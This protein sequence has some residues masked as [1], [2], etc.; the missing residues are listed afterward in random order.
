MT[1][2]KSY[3]SHVV[4]QCFDFRRM[5]DF[6]TGP[7]GFHLSDIGVARGHEMAF[8]TLDP[9]AEHHQLALASGRKGEGG[10][11][12]HLAFGV[13]SLKDLNERLQHLR[14]NNVDGIE[15]WTHASMLSV[16][17]RDPENNR[18]EFFMETPYYVQQ[19]V[20]EALD[21]D[22]GAD[23]SV[24]WEAI[25]DKFRGNPGFQPMVQWKR[26]TALARDATVA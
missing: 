8:L 4:L 18:L 19:P 5:V 1:A 10:A 23:E 12:H 9:A 11:L 26:E 24:V 21:V 7:L 2:P 6:Y 17:Y 22:I 25:A 13:R 3:L 20:A 14:K 15:L 16:Y